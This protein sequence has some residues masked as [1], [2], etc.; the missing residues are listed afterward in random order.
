MPVFFILQE[1]KKRTKS[2]NWT[3]AETSLL[4][5]VAIEMNLCKMLDSKEYTNASIFQKI[6]GKMKTSGYHRDASMIQLKYRKLKVDYYKAKK[7]QGVSGSSPSNFLFYAE[8]HTLLEK[9]P[10][11]VFAEEDGVE[12]LD[13][14][15]QEQGNFLKH[16]LTKFYFIISFVDSIILDENEDEEEERSRI[17]M[18]CDEMAIVEEAE[19][20]VLED[21]TSKLSFSLTFFS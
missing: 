13:F 20:T 1:I 11:T 3:S 19:I 8:M 16:F 7:A 21:V 5:E 10:M 2:K 4:L 9:R 6:E 15:S 18:E 14:H 12:D 17:S